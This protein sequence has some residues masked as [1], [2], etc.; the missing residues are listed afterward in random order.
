MSTS[1]DKPNSRRHFLRSSVALVPIA[2]LAGCDLRALPTSAPAAG[3]ASAAASGDAAREPYKQVLFDAR[4][5]AF[6]QAAVDRLI[7]AD[8]EGPGALDAGVP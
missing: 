1:S 8:A 5:W 4:E 3:N 2:S 7:P 6:V